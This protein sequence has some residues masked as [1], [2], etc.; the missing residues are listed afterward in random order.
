MRGPK[1]PTV[2]VILDT[3]PSI[4]D[5][6]M[7]DALSEILGIVRSVGA[8]KSVAV[9]PCSFNAYEPQFVRTPK[10]VN[11]IRPIGDSGTDITK[12][13]DVAM[14]LRALPEIIVVITDG[15]TPWPEQKPLG[16]KLVLI[17]LSSRRSES[18]LRPWMASIIQDH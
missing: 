16:V 15:E 10:Q 5:K 17:L 1:P 14:K 12:G 11:Y 6:N 7:K 8:S 18:N 13:F 4:S 9:I 3:S 2:A